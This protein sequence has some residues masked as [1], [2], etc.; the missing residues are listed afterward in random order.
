MFPPVFYRLFAVIVNI[1]VYRFLD[2]S[3]RLVG[4]FDLVYSRFLSLKLLIYPEDI[5]SKI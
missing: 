2:N 3:P 1:A 4:V 5:S